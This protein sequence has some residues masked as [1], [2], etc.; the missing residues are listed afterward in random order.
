MGMNFS[1]S[2][3]QRL[4]SI[5]R[6]HPKGTQSGFLEMRTYRYRGHS[7]SDP[8]SYRTNQELEKYRLD[9]R[10]RVGARSSRAMEN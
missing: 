7:L 2:P 6:F 8:A 5:V 4:P 10:S 1:L 3:R 9:D